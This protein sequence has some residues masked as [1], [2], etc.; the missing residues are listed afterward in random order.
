MSQDMFYWH[1]YTVTSNE[2]KD[3]F[4]M[5]QDMFYWHIYTVTSN[6]KTVYAYRAQR[7]TQLIWHTNKY[8]TNALTKLCKI[9]QVQ[10]LDISVTTTTSEC[11]IW[12]VLSSAQPLLLPLPSC[13]HWWLPITTYGILAGNVKGPLAICS[14]S[15]SWAIH[16]KLFLG[17]VVLLLCR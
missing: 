9:L 2:C 12:C 3:S 16:A 8:K 15:G 6:V 11:P 17:T 14:N 13:Q 4:D 7:W 1:I 10:W 5:S